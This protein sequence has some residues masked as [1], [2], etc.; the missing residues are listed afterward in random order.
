MKHIKSIILSLSCSFC[1]ASTIALA[2]NG[3]QSSQTPPNHGYMSS[4]RYDHAHPINHKDFAISI[5]VPEIN[6]GYVA[7]ANDTYFVTE[8]RSDPRWIK[9]NVSL[10]VPRYAVVGGTEP[11]RLLF[12]CRVPY[13]GSLHPGKLVEGRCNISYFG[14]EIALNSYEMLVSRSHLS[15]VSASY[16]YVPDGAIV[17]GHQNHTPVYICQAE[18]N[19]GLHPGKLVDQGCHITWGGREI[20]VSDYNVLVR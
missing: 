8:Y 3:Y 7:T 12:I 1:F 6:A 2:A 16:G 20:E 13:N 4:Y 19:H 9:S 15:W 14:R 17:G 11:G 18:F 10:P 5:N